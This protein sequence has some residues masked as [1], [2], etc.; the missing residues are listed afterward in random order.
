[1]KV[2][3][4]RNIIIQDKFAV[5]A[6]E[7]LNAVEEEDSYVVTL[8]NGYRTVAPKIAEGEIYEIIQE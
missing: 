5:D 6:G 2:R 8:K 1:M 3:F 4:L 7:V